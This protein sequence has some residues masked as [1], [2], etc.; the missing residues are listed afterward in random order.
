LP[1]WGMTE[2]GAVTTVAPDDPLER[3]VGTDGRACPGA[4]VCVCDA[5]GSP[6][7]P[8]REGDLH[9]RGAFLFAGYVQGREFTERYFTPDGWFTPG[10]GGGRDAAGYIRLTGRTKDLIIRGGENVPVKEIEDTLLR[11]PK[12]RA[13]V[14]VGL[15]HPRL[16][17]VGCACVIPEPG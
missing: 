15:P 3:V 12:V 6:C 13:V 7:P 5:D 10:D 8:G 16:G 11:H 1:V 14:L 2:T 4:E 17:E 9:T